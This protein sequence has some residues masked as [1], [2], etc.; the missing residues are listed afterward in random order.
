MKSFGGEDANSKTQHGQQQERGRPERVALVVGILYKK[1][2]LATV[3][4][5]I[6][7]A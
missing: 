6:W 5:E 4:L 7:G 2:R 1:C 3:E